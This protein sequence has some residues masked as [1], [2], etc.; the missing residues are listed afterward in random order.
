MSYCGPKWIS[1]YG[2]QAASN[3]DGLNPEQVGFADP[4]WRYVRYDPWWWLH[5]KPDPPPF[6]ID[7]EIIRDNPAPMQKVISII[8]IA[9]P[10]GRVEVQSVT[11]TEVISTQLAGRT[12][13]LRAVLHGARGTELA[14][15]T[16]IQT[17]AQACGCGCGGGEDGPALVQA[18]VSDVG[19]GTALSIQ[20]GDKTLWK[21]MAKKGKISIGAPSIKSAGNNQWSVQWKATVPGGAQDTWIRVSADDGRTWSS[22]ATG[23]RGTRATLDSQLLPAGKLLLEVV[24]HDGWRSVRSKPV[25]FENPELPP[26]PVVL[27]PDAGRELDEGQ[28]L[29]LWG[30]VACQRGQTPESFHYQWLLDGKTVGDELQLYT[31]VPA[32]GKHRCE[33]W[34]KNRAGKRLCSANAEFTSKR[35]TKP[36]A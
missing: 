4:W 15:G 2:H 1:I 34:V 33:L 24:I 8:G 14:T 5:Y 23:V 7:P 6:W 31:T 10:E 35:R 3:N 30:S 28:T 27:H 11:R 16:F 32:A 20:Q 22:A 13:G 21:Q 18:F 17:L 19:T 29:C 12:T 36:R 9:H 26:V 25:P